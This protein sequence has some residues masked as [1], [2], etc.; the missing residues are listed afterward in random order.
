MKNT[1]FI[2]VSILSFLLSNVKDSYAQVDS[3]H[4]IPPMCAFSASSSDVQDHQMVLTTTETTAFTVTIR[5]NVKTNINSNKFVRTVSLSSTSPQKINLN[6]SEYISSSDNTPA[7]RIG[8]QG[9]IGVGSLNQVLNT[10]GLIVS[11]PKKFFVSIQ[12]KSGAQGDLLTSKGT[13]GL[14]TDFYSGHMHS[15]TGTYDGYNGHFISV[16]ATENN[17]NITFSNPRI[18]FKNKPNT[19]TQSLNKGESYVVGISITDLKKQTSNFN[20]VNGTHITSNKPI[21]VNSGSWCATGHPRNLGNGRDVGFDQLVPTDVVGNEYILL[22][23]EGVNKGAEYNEKALV[24]ATENNTKVYLKGSS[25][26]R[27]TLN[28]GE[29]YFTNYSDFG[30]NK[31]LYIRSDKKIFCYQTLSGANKRQTA[32]FCFIPPLKC[33]ADKEVTIAYANKLSSLNVNP[34]L[35]LVTQKDSQ[36]KLNGVSLQN[37]SLYRKTVPGNTHWETYNIPMSELQKNRYKHG[38]DWIFKISSTNAL[39]AM[40]AVESNNVGGGGFFSGFGDVPQI[41]QNPE[42]TTQGLCGDNVKLTATGFDTYN[43]YK[44][45]VIVHGEHDAIFLPSNPGRYKVTGLSPCGGSDTESFPSDEIRILPCLSVSPENI[46]VTEGTSYA[47]FNVVLSHSWLAAD[48]VDVTFDYTTS[49]GTATGGKDYSPISDKAIIKSGQSSIEIKVPIV[50]DNLNENDE[51]FYITISNVSEAVE[52]TVTG[53]ATIKDDNDPLPT[54]SV[55]DQTFDEDA[56][57][58]N[59]PIRLNTESGKTI[60]LFYTLTDN[61]ANHPT[62]YTTVSYSGSL[63]FGAGETLK[64]IPLTI[65]DDIIFEPGGDEQFTIALSRITNAESGNI[66]ANISIVD[67]ESIPSVSVADASEEEGDNIIYQ[68]VLSHALDVDVSFSYA[69]DLTNGP[70]K[71]KQLDFINY[72]DFSIGTVVIPAGDLSANFPIF[73]TKDDNA[74][75]RA[76]TFSVNF[77]AINNASF[78][79]TSALGTIRDNEGDP[80]LSIA[81]ASG[82]EGDVIDF[83]ISVSPVKSSDITFDYR[84]IN[85]TA[86]SPSDFNGAGW[87]SI[88][89]PANQSNISLSITTVQDTEEEGTE[90]FTVEIGNPP[91]KVDIASGLNIATGTIIDDDDTPDARDDT[92]NVNEDAE[93]TGNVMTN[94]LGLTDAPVTLVANIDPPN[95]A[96]LINANGSFTYTPNLN[97]NGNDSFQYTIE[98]VDGDQSSAI[99]SITVNPMDDFPIANDDSFTISEDTQLNNNVTTNDQNL[100]DLPITVSLVSNVSHGSLSLNADGTF[101]Y[102]PNSEYFG[103]DNFSYKVTDGNDDAVTAYVDITVNFFNDAAPVAV[104]DN[105]S[106]NEDTPVSIDIL[107]NDTDIDGYLTIDRLSTLIKKNPSHGSLVQDLVTGEY[108]YTPDN[109]YTGAD[110]F[111]YTVKD[112]S[113]AESNIASV[114]INVTFDNDPPVANCKSDLIVFLDETGTYTLNPSEIDNGS[115]DDSDGG[116]VTL[117]VSPNTFNCDDTGKV[118]VTLKVTDEDNSSTTCTTE[119]TITDSRTP[120]VNEVQNDITVNTGPGI[121]G[122]KVNYTGPIFT[123]NCDGDKSGNLIAGSLSGSN[124]PV[125]ATIVTYEYTDGSGNGPIQSSFTVT[126]NDNED[127][128]LNNTADRNLSPNTSGCAYLVS[129][130][131]FDVTATDNCSISSITHNYGVGGNSL[132]GK[133]FPLGV[134]DVIWTVEDIHGNILSKVV[135]VTVS[136][137]LAVSINGPVGNESCDTE[138]AVFRGN[139]TGGNPAFIYDFF[140]NGIKVSD[141]VLGDTFTSSSLINGDRVKVRVTDSYGCQIESSEI[142]MTVHPKPSPLLFFD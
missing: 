70:G 7:D 67:N 57:S 126:V 142:V 79:N 135:E 26:A 127:P 5:N 118:W 39:N 1:L 63:S 25:V 87:T 14:G 4:Y 54:V 82:T 61:S 94:D 74:N 85:G 43:W 114:S 50:D 17:T 48:K 106:T 101:T 32:G 83:T 34:I 3:L 90:N 130:T 40:L 76:E 19:F 89:I 84:S 37:V 122:A 103:S 91:F 75:E 68:A 92:Y 112:N 11:G 49:N 66:N 93:L 104:D 115:N 9:I 53:T 138:D 51:D 62:D 141:G 10:E 77:S 60:E 6:Y 29:Y 16:M 45:G 128:T 134:T 58:V 55:N 71:A 44:D 96:L 15:L 108:T 116:T 140:V 111:T 12:N 65:I 69:I 80:S 102:M 28:K 99:V 46:E 131:S 72:D 33:T 35:K 56:G 109:N 86:T 64:N 132:N 133:S 136:T 120:I 59:I 73:T 20:K 129:G 81:P 97:Y 38:D 78:N 98:D 137:D 31:N 21:A 95:G 47:I 105:T 107:A 22:K 110:D 2:L 88:T 27:V 36:I 113:G 24:V 100:F 42:L 121:C 124:F 13:T 139:A 117:S 30:T 23:G 52:S 18:H 41:E 123:D 8:S 125:G 119:I